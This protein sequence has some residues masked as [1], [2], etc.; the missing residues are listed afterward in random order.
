MLRE[1]SDRFTEQEA[2][3]ALHTNVGWKYMQNFLELKR[4]QLAR[5]LEKINPDDSYEIAEIQGQIK[6]I[7]TI[8]NKPK[9]SFD[10]ENNRR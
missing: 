10:K 6:I 2:L 4:K 3:A 1:I 8:S 9:I 5:K 7:D